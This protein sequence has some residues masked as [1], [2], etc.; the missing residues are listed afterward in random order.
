[1]KSDLIITRFKTEPIIGTKS[2]FDPKTFFGSKMIDIEDEITIDNSLIQY[3]EVFDELNT[4]NNGFQYYNDIDYLEKIYL[5]SLSD[6][7]YN[8]HTITLSSQ[9]LLDQLNNTNWTILINWKDILTNYLFYR[10]KEVRTFKCI[11]YNEVIG[12]NINVFINK[13]IINNLLNRYQFNKL[14]LYVEYVALD[15]DDITKSP[16][17]LFSPNFDVNIRN[18][19]NLIKNVNVTVFDTL[20]NLQYKQ[21]KPSKTYKFNYYFDLIL[22]K[23]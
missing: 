16:D 3:S 10:L 2:F 20:L 23:I 18:D 4:N 6:V 1:M 5:I 15:N 22:T 17:L 9:S 8:N 11:N 14:N 19:S 21:T 12:E 13:Y 7:K